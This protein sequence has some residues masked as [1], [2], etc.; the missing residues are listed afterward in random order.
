MKK[1]GRKDI[2]MKC[3]N[4]MFSDKLE[5]DEFTIAELVQ[6]SKTSSEEMNRSIVRHRM[7]RLVKEGKA[8]SRKTLIDGSWV[9]VYRML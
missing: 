1:I 4:E 6:Q 3:L 5:E 9:V 2:L 7:G 8:T